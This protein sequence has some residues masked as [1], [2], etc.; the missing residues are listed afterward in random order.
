[1]HAFDHLLGV[2]WT[3]VADKKSCGG[4]GTKSIT[5]TV[6]QCADKCYGTTTAFVYGT[7]DFDGERCTNS[8]GCPCYCISAQ[9]DGSCSTYKDNIGY[10]YYKFGSYGTYIHII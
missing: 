4:A 8:K 1:M 10:R 6:R 5:K 2:Y 7:N 9:E 3:W